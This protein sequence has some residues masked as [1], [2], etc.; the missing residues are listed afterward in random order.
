MLSD[1]K[2]RALWHIWHHA[3]LDSQHLLGKRDISITQAEIRDLFDQNSLEPDIA[4]YRVV[5][6]NPRTSLTTENAVPVSLAARKALMVL[7]R[8]A[9][10]DEALCSSA[11]A[12]E[13]LMHAGPPESSSCR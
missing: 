1:P 4:K 2:R 12:K 5:P 3:W 8:S 10:S 7:W 9:E 6:R 13:W 11:V